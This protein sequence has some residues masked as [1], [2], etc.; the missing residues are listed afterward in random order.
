MARQDERAPNNGKMVT[1]FIFQV[2]N[3]P[4]ALYKAL[5][6]FATTT[7]RIF[8]QADNDM[9]GFRAEVALAPFDRGVNQGF[10]LLAHPSDIEGIDELR[11]LIYRRSGSHG[12]WRRSTRVFINDLRKQL[13]IWRSLTT[14]VM[15]QYRR[16]TQEAWDQLSVE[17]VTPKTIG[18]TP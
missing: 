18:E 13:L 15:D 7:C 14:E 5:G 1:S 2:K 4:A 10:A 12:D 3:I 11:I 9:L 17:D 6:A 8:R 16:R